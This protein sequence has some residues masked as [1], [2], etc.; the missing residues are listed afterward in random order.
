MNGN[1]SI[2]WIGTIGLR[3][4]NVYM[5]DNE[6]T[7]SNH[8]Y[9]TPD[10]DSVYGVYTQCIGYPLLGRSS[11][12]AVSVSMS[13]NMH[14]D[15]IAAFFFLFFF[16]FFFFWPG[17]VSASAT[18]ALSGHRWGWFSALW[19]PLVVLRRDLIQLSALIY[20]RGDHWE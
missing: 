7:S 17:T 12:F 13:F 14:V 10:L 5:E 2:E 8:D 6:A 18:V 16:C 11:R 19:W 3:T 9:P 20:A 1:D 4:L 15:N